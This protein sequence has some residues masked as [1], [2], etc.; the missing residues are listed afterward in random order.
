MGNHFGNMIGKFIERSRKMSV[1][2]VSLKAEIVKKKTQQ[3]NSF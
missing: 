3:D 2:S 1:R